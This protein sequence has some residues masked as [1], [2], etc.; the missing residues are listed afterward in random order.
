MISLEY[1]D[2]DNLDLLSQIF[3]FESVLREGLIFLSGPH[4][5]LLSYRFEAVEESR[6]NIFENVF[7]RRS[8]CINP[9]FIMWQEAAELK[10]LTAFSR[11]Q[12]VG[13]S[14]VL[15]D[16]SQGLQWSTHHWHSTVNWQP[17]HCMWLGEFQLRLM[18]LFLQFVQL[19][20]SHS[21]VLPKNTKMNL[22]SVWNFCVK[23]GSG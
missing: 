14:H 9:S 23:H 6:S 8:T 18:G 11:V 12:R 15:Q 10:C 19:V 22:K 20:T 7:K 4:W 5:Y 16:I 21:R 2:I 13:G 17:P 1:Q 3:S